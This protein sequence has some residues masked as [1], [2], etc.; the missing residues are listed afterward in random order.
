MPG[1]AQNA[2]KIS[3]SRSA[4]TSELA[5]RGTDAGGN[6]SALQPAVALLLLDRQTVSFRLAAL[7]A[8]EELPAM[9]QAQDRIII[10]INGENGM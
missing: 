9:D 3:A 1:D 10:G 7:A 8:A 2:S 4:T 5:R 6:I